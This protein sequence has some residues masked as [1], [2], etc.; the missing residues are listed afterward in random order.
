MVHL[1]LDDSGK[2]SQSTMPWV[3]MAGYLATHDAFMA[4][5]EKW[6]GLLVKH[7]ISQ[8]H[9][10][11]LIPMEGEYKKLGWDTKKRDD[12]VNEFVDAINETPMTGAGVAVEMAAWRKRK[13]AY[14]KFP[15]GTVHQFCL[16]RIMR[17]IVD[18]LHDVLHADQP[19]ALVFDTDQ[20]FGVARFNLFCALMKHD[21]RAAQRLVSIT[22]GHPRWYPGLQ[23]ADLLAWETRKELMQQRGGYR[24]TTRWQAM[25]TQMPNYHLEYPIGERWNDEQF[26]KSMPEIIERFSALKTSSKR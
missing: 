16:E 21:P 20:E 7:G 19:L 1:F 23:A 5:S 8:I 2:E 24:S 15:W 22:F 25:F 10:K 4:L 6:I 11:E 14:P 17:R 26:D 12:V 18:R 13:K 3:C 9:M